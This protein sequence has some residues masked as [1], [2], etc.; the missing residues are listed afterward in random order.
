MTTLYLVRHGEAEGNAFRRIHGQYDSILTP[1][2]F[3][4]VEALARRFREIPVDACYA[5]DLTRTSLTARAVYIPKELPLHRDAAFREICLGRWEDL[6]FG[7]LEQFEP[8]AM[9][10]FRKA[11]VS[12][13]IEG[14][15][16]FAG[17][18]G[19]FIRGMTAAATRYPGKT[20]AI[21][22]HSAVLR[23]VLMELFFHRDASLVPYCDN[24]AVSKLH[25]DGR[26]F[27]YEFLNDSS[28]LPENL[29]RVR[30]EPG[31][32]RNLWY[33]PLKGELP[34]GLP[35]PPEHNRS[36]V[37]MLDGNAVG[38][39][40]LDREKGRVTRLY[41][42]ESCRDMG[43]EDQLLGQAVSCLRRWGHHTMGIRR[44]DAEPDGLLDRY[45]FREEGDILTYNLD[46]GVY[47][48]EE[49]GQRAR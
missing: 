24:T 27:T 12:W 22:C 29:S 31:K 10:C 44:T 19:R 15:E 21:F 49:A 40:S 9:T 45:G 48:W 36:F 16:R 39:V 33:R 38:L 2:G 42:L 3:R 26:T 43:M 34:Q 4:Q 18:T 32:S 20:I 5:S 41:L 47:H 37:A 14:G 35:Q 30:R 28:H 7:Y 17:Y 25:W 46:P 8:E 11:P 13:H 23:G 6:P 1:T